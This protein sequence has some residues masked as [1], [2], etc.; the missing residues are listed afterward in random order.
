MGS[1]GPTGEGLVRILWATASL[2]RCAQGRQEP[3]LPVTLLILAACGREGLVLGTPA[4]SVFA[5]DIFAMSI[6]TW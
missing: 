5:L 2:A 1:Y 6:F 3:H 4:I